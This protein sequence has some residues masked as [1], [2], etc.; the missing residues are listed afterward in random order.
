MREIKLSK[1][2]IKKKKCNMKIHTHTH[3]LKTVKNSLFAP[4]LSSPVPLLFNLTLVPSLPP[5]GLLQLHFPHVLI[6]ALLLKYPSLPQRKRLLLVMTSFK[7]R[8]IPLTASCHLLNPLITMHLL[9]GRRKKH[10]KKT[11]KLMMNR[12]D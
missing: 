4:L 7:I 10:E 5:S 6:T 3:T 11:Q 9:E 2:Q 8:Y 1:H 12:M